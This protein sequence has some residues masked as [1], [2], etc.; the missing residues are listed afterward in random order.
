MPRPAC[1]E[2][3][4]GITLCWYTGSNNKKEPMK[5]AA[6][7]SDVSCS[8]PGYLQKQLCYFSMASPSLFCNSRSALQISSVNP[9][10][11]P[12]PHLPTSPSPSLSICLFVCL[13]A[14]LCLTLSFFLCLCLSVCLSLS[15]CLAVSLSV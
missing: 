14:S 3:R 9:H 5:N 2:R 8:V 12:L 6:M 11:P 10:P 1:L 7:R 13:S 15:G 4:W